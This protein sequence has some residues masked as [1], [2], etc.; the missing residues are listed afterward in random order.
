MS[1]IRFQ[2]DIDFLSKHTDVILL[3]AGRPALVAVA[4]RLQARVMTS[5]VAGKEGKSLGWINRKFLS[6]GQR[7]TAFDNYGGE[8]RFWLG[9]EGGQYALWFAKGEPFDIPHW[10]TPAGF[11]AGS[12]DVT[13][14]GNG[15]VALASRFDVANFSGTKF[16][17]A[18]RR[19]ISVLTGEQVAENL[20]AS[21]PEGVDWVAFQSSN[22][23]ANVGQAAWAARE[24]LVSVWILGQFNP[25]PRGLVIVPFQA[26]AELGAMPNGAYFGPMGSDR[27][28]FQ[29]EYVLFRCDG[30]YRSKLGV[31]AA[32]ARNVL[33]SFD[34]QANLLTIV[35][36]NL[37]GGAA[38]LPYVNSLW[39]VQKEPF[40]GD[41]VNSYNDGEEKPGGGQLGPFYEIETSSPAA[42]LG[43]NQALT[44]VHRTFHFSGGFEQLNRIAQVVL[45][46]DLRKV[47]FPKA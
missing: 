43:V 30:K 2:D 36:Y 12:F 14:Q 41:V 27:F 31:S 17:V 16:Q 7:N 10:V 13:S 4:P 44:H 18:V 26:G 35:Q 40:A 38:A 9:P 3:D 22:T 21:V 29:G 6:S 39:E 8:D 45:G 33:G 32:R 5:T 24:G 34:P 28:R 1:D 20:G 15:S 46:V 42:E 25:L 11:N 37:P 47:E 19:V 23:V